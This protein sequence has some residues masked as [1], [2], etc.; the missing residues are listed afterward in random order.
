MSTKNLIILCSLAALWGASFFFIRVSVPTFGPFMLVELRLLL[1]VGALLLFAWMTR[2]KLD[3]F[4]HWKKYIWLGAINAAIPFALISYAEITIPSSLAAILNATTPIFTALIAWIWI[5]EPL[6]WKKISGL[7]VGLIGVIVLVGWTPIPLH[8]KV[9]IAIICS[10]LATI[11]YGFGTIYAKRNFVSSPLELAI[12]QLLGA[13]V[14]LLPFS[15]ADL[16]LTIPSL[17]ALFS[18]LGLAIGSTAIAYLFYFQLLREIG[19]TQTLYVTFLV[20][21]FGVIW[22]VLFLQEE[23]SWGAGL[24]ML[25]IFASIFLLAEI[26]IRKKRNG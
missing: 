6:T 20:P 7:V 11:G 2:T 19:P 22:G 12:G 4:P 8:L 13:S 10:L 9:F 1:A 17:P 3:I 21:V 16:P 15:L 26:R 25:L 23:M 18:L 5:R 14:F 24:G